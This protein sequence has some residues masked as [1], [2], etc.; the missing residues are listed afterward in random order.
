MDSSE[1]PS[2]PIT[3]PQVSMG[4]RLVDKGEGDKEHEKNRFNDYQKS[5]VL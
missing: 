4:R 2:D 3:M 1:T 5:V